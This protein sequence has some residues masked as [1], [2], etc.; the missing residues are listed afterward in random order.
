MLSVGPA[1]DGDGHVSDQALAVL[2]RTSSGGG[3]APSPS[4]ELSRALGAA[5]C[6]HDPRLTTTT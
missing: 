5:P 2:Q 6:A 1:A 3:Q 4:S